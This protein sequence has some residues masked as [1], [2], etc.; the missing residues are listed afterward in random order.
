MAQ[1]DQVAALPEVTSLEEFP[2]F[3]RMLAQDYAANHQHWT[4]ATVPELLRAWVNRLSSANRVPVG[5]GRRVRRH[6]QRVHRDALLAPL[7]WEGLSESLSAVR[8][9]D[10]GRSLWSHANGGD[11]TSAD[12]VQTAEQFTSFLMWLSE[13][14]AL[15]EAELDHMNLLGRGLLITEGRWSHPPIDVW[16]R[17]WA[18]WL[19]ATYLSPNKIRDRSE[20]DPVTWHSIA[21]QLAA[22]RVY[23]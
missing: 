4:V 17:G 13:D 14:W 15:E 1:H 21:V 3:L 6:A 16:L 22:A 20:L 5:E 8:T 19:D 7:G 23:L 9:G 2:H 18:R 12:A 11:A 10:P